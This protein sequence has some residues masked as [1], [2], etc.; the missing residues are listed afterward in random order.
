MDKQEVIQYLKNH[1]HVLKEEE[2]LYLIQN[3]PCVR[4]MKT[5]SDGIYSFTFDD[6]SQVQFYVVRAARAGRGQ[7][8]PQSQN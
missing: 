8:E 5:E 4:T 3:I 1:A 7:G 6:F 2:Y